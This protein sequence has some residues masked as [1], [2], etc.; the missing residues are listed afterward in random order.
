MILM[1]TC[2]RRE[3]SFVS[4]KFEGSEKEEVPD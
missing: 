4:P 1:A 2:S 3:G